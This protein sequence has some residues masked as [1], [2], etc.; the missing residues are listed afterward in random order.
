MLDEFRPGSS[1]HVDLRMS[2]EY[3]IRHLVVTHSQHAWHDVGALGAKRKNKI[4][5]R[6]E[7]KEEIIQGY[8]CNIKRLKSIYIYI[9]L[10]S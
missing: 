3:V 10:K 8:G 4:I 7:G 5:L 9:F 6:F 1:G 2:A